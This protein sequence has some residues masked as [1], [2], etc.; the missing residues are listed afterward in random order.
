MD[1]YI[2]VALI[3]LGC[4]V[5][6]AICINAAIAA[7]INKII[8]GGRQDKNPNFK[9]FT[10]QDFDLKSEDFPVF[11]SGVDLYGKLYFTQSI[12]ECKSLVIFVHGFG[13]GSSSYMT[14][15]AHFAKKGNLVL[16]VDAFGCNNSAGASIRGFYAGAEAVI[17]A[18]I[19]VNSDKRL[20]DM[21]KIL[22]GHSWGAYSVLAASKSVSVGGVVAM[23]AFDS[24]AKMVTTALKSTGTFGKLYAPFVYPF[25]ALIFACRFGVGGNTKASKAIEKSGTK[26]LLIHGEKDALVPLKLSAAH[27]AKGENITSV[28]LPDKGHNPYNTVSAEAKLKE[29]T[30][31]H[32]FANEDEG[33]AYYASFDWAAATEDDEKV[34]SIIDD[35]IAKA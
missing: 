5:V 9:Y 4:I 26:A 24:P 28:I 1:L 12:E 35:F 17:A 10:P 32:N 25:I 6:I 34:M 8:F 16:A 11:Y 21:N 33:K 13:A 19:G 2:Q 27:I 30:S 22:V 14:E 3:V 18:Y 31:A 29:L 20:K 7:S 23:S 15:I